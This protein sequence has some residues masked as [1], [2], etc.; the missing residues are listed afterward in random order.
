[1]MTSS[2]TGSA[3][4]QLSSESSSSEPFNPYAASAAPIESVSDQVGETDVEAY[5]NYHL[6]H[7]ASCKSI[8][9]LYYLGGGFATVS[10]VLMLAGEAAT[11][12]DLRGGFLPVLIG[13]LYF[14]LGIF[15][16]FVGR[17]LRRLQPWSRFGAIALSVIGLLGIPVGTLISIYVLYLMLS[18]KGRVVYSESYKR[19][20]EQTPHIKYRTS[21]VVWVLLGILVVFLLLGVVGV[22]LA[23]TL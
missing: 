15:Q 16:I 2:D 1:M 5:R 20:V 10:G 14:G 3:E 7:E 17:G 22:V 23:T 19:I 4:S 11:P 12:N 9:I 8:G 6:K 18:A 13:L 21:K